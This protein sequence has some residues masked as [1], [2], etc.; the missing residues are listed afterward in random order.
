APL[1]GGATRGRCPTGFRRIV[2]IQILSSAEVPARCPITE[3]GQTHMVPR[4]SA[5]DALDPELR[6]RL[7]A[8][9]AVRLGD[10]LREHPY[11]SRFGGQRAVHQLCDN[12]PRT[13]LDLD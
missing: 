6:R 9:S 1:P 10:P 5:R 4:R 11:G 3:S 13:A 2:T 12:V 8:L 7:S